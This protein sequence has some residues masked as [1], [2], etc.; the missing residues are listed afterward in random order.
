MTKGSSLYAGLLAIGLVN[1]ARAQLLGP[2]DTRA[3]SDSAATRFIAEARAGTA[4]Y[5]DRAVAIADGYHMVG[6][7]L[8][9]MGEHWLNIALILADTVDAA[10]PPVLIYVASPTGPVLAGAAYTRMLTPVQS[11]PDFPSGLHAWHDHSGFIDEEALP[12]SHVGHGMHDAPNGTRLGI[13]H[14]WMW[15]DNPE[16]PWTA[17]NW[18]LPFVRAGLN[19]PRESGAA[20]R[21]LALAPD[22]GRYYLGVFSTIGK[23]DAREVD[24]VRMVLATAA[25]RVRDVALVP[26]REPEDSQIVQ[27]RSIWE[28]LWPSIASVLRTSTVQRLEGLKS[29]WWW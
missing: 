13:L 8:P 15:Q 26:G 21:S 19:A 16:G 23:L 2:N 9:S 27:L 18:A 25:N 10:R 17:D 11:Y 4:K 22:S 3:T 20:A 24:Q 5:R 7:D 28:S 1:V 29:L 14:L 6:P 12:M